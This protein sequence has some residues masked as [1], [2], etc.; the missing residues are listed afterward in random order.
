MPYP[1]EYRNKQN[2]FETKVNMIVIDKVKVKIAE[3][4]LKS[5]HDTHMYLLA[6]NTKTYVEVIGDHHA[7]DV[8][9]TTQNTES[10]LV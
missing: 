10:A 2:Y 3:Y 9:L 7:R 1:G 4:S 5:E 6:P 8:R